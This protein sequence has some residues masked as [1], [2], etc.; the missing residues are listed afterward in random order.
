MPLVIGIHPDR[1]GTES[2]SDKWAEF[3]T[4]RGVKVRWL[5]LLADDALAQAAACDGVMWRWLH[6][7]QHKQ[8]AQRILYTVEHYLNK[9]VFPDTFTS[10]HY[11][12]KVAQHYL[13]SALNAP[14]PRSWVFWNK[15]E[16]LAW[17]RTAEFP[18][19][20]KLS[21]GAG[22]SNVLKVDTPVEAAKL[23]TRAFDH[24]FFPYTMNEF[25]SKNLLPLN[26]AAVSSFLKRCKQS[27]FFVLTNT[28]PPLPSHDAWKPEKGYVYF[29]EFLP[30]NTFDTR[31]TV[32]GNKAFAY[33]RLN[34]PSDFR[35]SGSGLAKYE[36]T[37]IDKEC[38]AIAFELSQHGRF[39][40]M[41]Y[42]FLKRAGK[43][44]VVEISYTFVDWMVHECLGH[45][46]SSLNWHEGQMWPEE[47]QVEVF[48]SHIRAFKEKSE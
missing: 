18:I 17:T 30:N 47:A 25:A 28:Y 41:A 8:S 29:Q 46:D 26:R 1:V 5:N 24:G 7:E 42:D 3:L 38:I 20:F 34:R 37:D 43:P 15:E 2:Y 6:N 9:P 22:S 31:V 32:I 40:S 39:Q 19:V 27:A 35:A 44:V 36:S 4:A 10:W 21:I 14:T 33:R 45:W 16:A 12:E 13:L 48:L 23:I 11:D